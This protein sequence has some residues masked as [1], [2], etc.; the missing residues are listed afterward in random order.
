MIDHEELNREATRIAKDITM[1]VASEDNGHVMAALV[2]LVATRMVL[3]AGPDPAPG[4]HDRV[5]DA[6]SR[7]VRRL[8]ETQT[9]HLRRNPDLAEKLRK[10]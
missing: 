2:L 6:M 9:A 10:K 7:S 8:I 3:T 1:L 4:S 5:L